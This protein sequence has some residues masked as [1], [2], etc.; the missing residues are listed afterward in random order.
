MITQKNFWLVFGGVWFGVGA[1]FVLVGA[2]ILWHEWNLDRQLARGG[3]AAQGV[4]LAK[5][6]RS[7][8]DQDPVFHVEYRY[9]S[10]DGV[11]NEATTEVGGK[12]WDALAEGGPLVVTYA[13]EQPRAHRVAGQVSDNPL[14]GWI[15]ALV[16]GLLAISGAV[17]L[18]RA[19][20][21]RGL[22]ERLAREGARATAEVVEVVPT[23]F[24]VN[25]VPRWE[26]R[27]R[28]RDPLG[29]AHSGRSSPVAEEE[30]RRWKPGDR[31][32]VRYLRNRPQTSVWVGKD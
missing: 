26:I 17:I 23:V 30:A 29:R 5:S 22:A 19:M 13:R 10:A 24:Q 12:T 16:G 1:V 14:V 4:V 6:M 3:A 21:Q 25:Q 9:T 15:V 20:N 18:W 32:V 11:V 27:Y 2:G 8:K 31:G 28:Y 7:R